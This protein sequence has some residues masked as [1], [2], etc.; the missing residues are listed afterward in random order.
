[1]DSQ[2]TQDALLVSIFERI[3]VTNLFYVEIGV[4]DVENRGTGSNTRFLAT[5]K[6]PGVCSRYGA[7]APKTVHRWAS[8]TG[9]LFDKDNENHKIGL[10]RHTFTVHNA[11]NAF[12][13]R[14]VPLEPDYISIDIDS[15][16][17]WVFKGLTQGG[18]R[19]RVVSI[20][21]DKWQRI[22]EKDGT[23]GAANCDADPPRTHAMHG[24]S[25]GALWK[26]AKAQGYELVAIACDLDAF[27]VRSDLLC[28]GTTFN[29]IREVAAAFGDCAGSIDRFQHDEVRY[30]TLLAQTLPWV[31]FI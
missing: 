3:G 26:V 11:A 15:C 4:N 6:W 23:S 14:G 17:I 5:T 27:F 21:F 30:G 10:Y 13:E 16:D 19:P 28:N 25:L 2:A 8:W 1:M 12:A 31:Q 22:L 20:E 29:D 7:N 18:Y 9:V 24:S